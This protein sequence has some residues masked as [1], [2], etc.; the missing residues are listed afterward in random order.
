M[1]IKIYSDDRLMS[2]LTHERGWKWAIRM[3]A[4]VVSYSIGSG[5]IPAEQ[6]QIEKAY[7]EGIAMFCAAGQTASS[8]SYPACLPETFA[9]GASDANDNLWSESNRGVDLDILAPSYADDNGVYNWTLDITGYEGFCPTTSV[10]CGVY[11]YVCRIM[12]TSVAAPIAAGVA[13][14]VLS[15]K[16]T[17]VCDTCNAEAVYDVIRH[18]AEDEIH[19]NDPPGY[20]TLFGWGRVN[21]ARAILSVVRGD[22][23]TNG[24]VNISDGTYLISYVMSGGPAPLPTLATGDADCNGIVNIS[25]AVYIIA[26]IFGGG[27]PP[28]IC[29]RYNY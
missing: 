1:P 28:G 24:V 6:F 10:C 26:Y 22:V 27:E 5:V 4:D 13:A 15:H 2:D 14:Q 16:P 20:D 17:L 21:A 23:D 9:V 3:S 8:V 11:D 7:Q 25:D 19:D 29:Y 12:G 18:S